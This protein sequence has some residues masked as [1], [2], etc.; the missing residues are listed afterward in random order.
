MT[1]DHTSFE[2]PFIPDAVL[3]VQYWRRR[4]LDEPWQRLMMA[5]LVDGIRC[6]QTNF[7]ATSG[8][9]RLL[10]GEAAEWL[11][12]TSDYGPFS[13]DT[14]CHAVGIDPEYLRDGLRR[15]RKKQHEESHATDKNE[16]VMRT[17][18]RGQRHPKTYGA[19][20]RPSLAYQARAIETDRSLRQSGKPASVA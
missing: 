20:A 17:S 11:F 15:W 18:L 14:I 12:A 4:K 5:V 13:C 7:T 8:E 16:R 9:R 1:H 3:P 10:F 2:H 6:Y 19:F